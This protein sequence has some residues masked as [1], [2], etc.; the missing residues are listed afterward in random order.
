MQTIAKRQRQ[1]C[2]VYLKISVVQ[3]I[4]FRVIEVG[5]KGNAATARCIS[6]S[7]M[8]TELAFERVALGDNDSEC[9]LAAVQKRTARL[10]LHTS[11]VHDYTKM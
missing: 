3:T 9:N 6:G 5:E 8:S 7:R 4:E 10:V 2:S 1:Q 11:T